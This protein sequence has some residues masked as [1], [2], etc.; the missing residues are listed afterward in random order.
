MIYLKDEQIFTEQFKMEN[1]I[2]THTH[3]AYS[4]AWQVDNI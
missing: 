2:Y 4:L 1:K 3:V